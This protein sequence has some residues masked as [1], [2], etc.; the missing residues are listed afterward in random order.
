VD[1]SETR[2]VEGVTPDEVP[3]PVGAASEG[4][5]YP[6]PKYMQSRQTLNDRSESSK[7]AQV[8][9]QAV[10]GTNA[11]IATRQQYNKQGQQQ[12][13]QQDPQRGPQ[14]GPQPRRPAMPQQPLTPGR[15]PQRAFNAGPQQQRAGYIQGN[16]IPPQRPQQAPNYFNN[17]S[18]NLQHLN[19][20]QNQVVQPPAQF[21]RGQQPSNLAHCETPPQM[22]PQ[23]HNP[24]A[25]FF[26]ARAA[27]MVQV[28]NATL[29]PD[30]PTFNPHA[31]SPSIRKTSGIDH[32]KS[33]PVN[34]QLLGSQNPASNAQQ[35]VR[36]NFANPQLDATRRIGMPGN[37]SPVMN[38]STYKPPGPANAKRPSDGSGVRYASSVPWIIFAR[39]RSDT[40]LRQ[41]TT[42]TT[43]RSAGSPA[44]RGS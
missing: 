18:P 40:R 8:V 24:P 12:G 36:T 31:E 19:A 15:S 14:Q 23:G 22:V 29:P 37:P 21:Q 33:L 38:R 27:E 25:A 16:S 11:N 44:Q 9:D 4:P 30:A 34:R 1:F 20:A 32:T 10:S 35:T 3:L 43:C 26:T 5:E 7:T 2:G 41:A 17:N 6:K 39:M 28:A 42:N 13:F